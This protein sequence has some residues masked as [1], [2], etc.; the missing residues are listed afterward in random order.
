MCARAEIFGKKSL[1][2]IG[3]GAAVL[4]FSFCIKSTNRCSY[5]LS[6][7]YKSADLSKRKTVVVFPGVNCIGIENKKD[8]TDDYGGLNS[9]PES[10]IRKFYFPEM[11]S[12]IKS[13][14]SG[15]SI[16]V[17]EDYRP[18]LVW[19]TLATSSV[20]MKTGSD[21][22][23]IE[24][25]VP[26]KARMQTVGMD[27]MVVIIIESIEFKRNNFRCEYY[28]DDKSRVPAN[29][30]VTAKIMIWDYANSQ[31]VFYG[32]ISSKIEFTFGLQRKHWDESARALAKKIV[33]AA[34]CL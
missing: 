5:T 18:G 33:T 4:L 15:D 27:S 34:K 6:E 3:I 26:E 1:S 32:P 14:V 12:T 22:V 19:D 2:L 23:P 9:P 31:P 11:F 13:F 29:L 10:R 17:L 20:S 16:A 30:E 28:W 21:S 8:V 24:Y 7:Q 25:A